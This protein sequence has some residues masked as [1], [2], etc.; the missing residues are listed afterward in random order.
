MSML[1]S[2]SQQANDTC[3]ILHQGNSSLL[4][5]GGAAFPK[6]G[7]TSDEIRTPSFPVVYFGCK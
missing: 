5:E 2:S 1:L 6:R 7:T 4:F 3:H